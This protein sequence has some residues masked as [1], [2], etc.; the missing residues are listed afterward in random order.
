MVFENLDVSDHSEVRS[1]ETFTKVGQISQDLRLEQAFVGIHKACNS[2][3]PTGDLKVKMQ[4][5]FETRLKSV[6]F[7][8]QSKQSKIWPDQVSTFPSCTSKSG[9][10]AFDAQGYAIV[11]TGASRSVIG[12]ENLPQMMQLLDSSARAHIKERSSCI[13]FRFGNNQIE[14]SFKKIWIPF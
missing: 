7:A 6:H 2:I 13:G 1:D 12:S 5:L 4:K 10:E 8:R 11:D 14:Y 9:K 3:D